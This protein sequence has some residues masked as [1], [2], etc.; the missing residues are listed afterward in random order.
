MGAIGEHDRAMI[1]L[2]LRGARRRMKATTGRCEGRKPFGFHASEQPALSLMRKMR[3][4]GATNE[5][6]ATELNGL[7]HAPRYS[8]EWRRTT[9]AKILKRDGEIAYATARSVAARD[10]LP[11]Q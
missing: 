3:A 4:E 1:V 10:R 2:K 7:G 6:I 9:V 8:S 11:P 5:A